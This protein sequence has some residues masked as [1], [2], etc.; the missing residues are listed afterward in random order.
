TTSCSS[1]SL[2]DALPISVVADQEARRIFVAPLH[3]GDVGE[4]QRTA[5]RGDRRIADLLQIVDGAV[6][7]DEDLRTLGFD[8]AGGRHG[9]AA[10]SE[11]HTSE[12]QSRSDLV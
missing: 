8:R 11:E 1:L 7:P 5:L 12:L 4:L 3:F 2:H 9:V 6:Q 10:R